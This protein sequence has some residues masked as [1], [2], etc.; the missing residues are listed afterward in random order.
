LTLAIAADSRIDFLEL[1]RVS[2]L[3]RSIAQRIVSRRC[4]GQ[5]HIAFPFG[6]H[7]PLIGF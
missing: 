5:S 7:I 6:S 2:E 1:R 4:V 3:L